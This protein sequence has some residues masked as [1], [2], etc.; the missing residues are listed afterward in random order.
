MDFSRFDRP[1]DP[2]TRE[3]LDDGKTTIL[4]VGRLIPN[5]KYEDLIKT[6]SCY[7]KHFNRDSRLVL[8]GDRRGW[9]RYWHGLEGLVERLS[10]AD[11][12]FAGHVE[13]EELLAYYEAADVYLSLSEHEGFG[14]PLVEAFYKK[15]PVLAY[16]AG[17]VK[18]TM[19]GG[20]ILLAEKDFFRTAA[21]IDALLCDERLRLS[22]IE[23]QTRALQKYSREN[24]S[25]VLLGH[26]EEVS[27]A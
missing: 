3:L 17:A 16:R 12:H 10:L 7:K 15:I 2:V 6:F 8:A 22:I 18:E 20:G 24:T 5:K 27:R 11:V 4:F 21:L 9:E 13:F 23:G 19:N 25:R 14:V 1:A 26:V